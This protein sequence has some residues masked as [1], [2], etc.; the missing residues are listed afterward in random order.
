MTGEDRITMSQMELKRL[1]IIRKAID[2]LIS[3]I[4]AA[5]ILGLCV[6]QIQRMITR[7]KKEGDK[8]II[9]KSLGKP[10]NN[11]TDEKI[12]TK[13]MTLYR[14]HYPDFGPTL[15]S[16]KLWERHR[17]KINDET[18][19]LWLIEAGIDY[20]SRK[21]RPHRQWR[22]RKSSS[23]EMTQMD[24]SPHDWLEGRGP[25]L[26]LMGYKDDA[27]GDVFARFYWYEGTFPAM[28]GLWRYIQ[29]YGIPQSVY[30]DKHSTYKSPAKPSIEDELEDTQPMTQFGRA[31]EELEIEVIWANS[32]QAKGRIERQFR[33]FQHRLVKELRLAAAK[34]LEEANKV[35][36][37]YL[38]KYNK[39]FSVAAANGTNLHRPIPKNLDL[40]TVFCVKEARVLRNDF[41]VS[42]KTKL[43]QIL[44]AVRAR[45]LEVRE[46][47]DGSLHISHKG[48]EV[49]F[50][51]VNHRPGKEESPKPDP[52]PRL[53]TKPVANHPWR[54]SYKTYPLINSY[55][56]KEESSKEEK[57]LLL[58]H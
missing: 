1:H 35:L 45:S 21:P 49:R 28:D 34:T 53:V 29:K 43:Y 52:K 42:Y 57:E 32:P 9:H 58:V 23:G 50:R 13:A 22:Q 20:D 16:E 25:K 56:Q 55:S 27:T 33:T 6:R 51:E 14:T 48:Q 19:R 41:T 44:D 40:R 36:A 30:L 10:S 5:D 7:I 11:R 15:G 18:L 38:P 54:Q 26:V 2:E 39:R 31:C 24:G 8:G 4:E 17:I 12:K 47:L 3:Q 46:W 37:A